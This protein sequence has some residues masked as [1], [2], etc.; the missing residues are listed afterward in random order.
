MEKQKFQ[1]KYDQIIYTGPI[2][3]YFSYEF[4]PLEYR[5]LRFERE[6]QAVND[7]PGNTAINYI[8]FDV[9]WIRILEHKFFKLIS[10]LYVNNKRI[11][12]ALEIR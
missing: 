4:R 6:L 10:K 12:C 2:D 7:F 9:L 11:C 5:S 8:D 1:Q 3:A